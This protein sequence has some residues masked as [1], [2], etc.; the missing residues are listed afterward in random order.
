MGKRQPEEG[1][2]FRR[3]LASKGK[4][5]YLRKGKVFHFFEKKK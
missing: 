3:Y 4:K 2:G 1:E 5:I